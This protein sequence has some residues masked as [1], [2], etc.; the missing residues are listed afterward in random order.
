[1][2]R[3]SLGSVGTRSHSPLEGLAG[4]PE[5][6][7]T[8]AGA[9][10]VHSAHAPVSLPGPSPDAPTPQVPECRASDPSALGASDATVGR[11]TPAPAG[12]AA[13]GA[14]LGAV[15]KPTATV[16][17]GFATSTDAMTPIATVS[18]SGTR[19]AGRSIAMGRS[20]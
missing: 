15:S 13:G 5:P 12:T 6:T 4:A 16:A 2:N 1:M 17:Q 18:A 3:A 11:A 9:T 10:G 19:P 20:S 14:C 8:V 7:G